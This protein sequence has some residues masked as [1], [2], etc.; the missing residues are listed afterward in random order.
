MNLS[1]KSFSTRAVHAGERL[2]AGKYTPVATAIHPSVGYMYESMDDVDEIFSG[3]QEGYVYSRYG[4]PTVTAFEIALANLEGAETA[5][6]FASGMA[7]GARL[8]ARGG[9]KGRDHRGRRA[10]CVRRDL[11]PGE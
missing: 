11:Q 7:A 4:S 6:G 9:C 8:S 3:D 1:D 10:G 2:P 5:Y